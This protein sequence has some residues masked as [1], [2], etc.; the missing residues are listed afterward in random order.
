MEGHGR[1]RE[2]KAAGGRG[3]GFTRIEIAGKKVQGGSKAFLHPRLIVAFGVQV[4]PLMEFSLSLRLE[5]L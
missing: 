2:I 3:Q 1:F 5:S 4:G